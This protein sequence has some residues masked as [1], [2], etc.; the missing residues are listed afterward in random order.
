MA[1]KR[2]A[3]MRTRCGHNETV[4]EICF[5]VTAL[6]LILANNISLD[7]KGLPPIGSLLQNFFVQWTTEVIVDFAII[8]WLTVMARQPVLAVSHRL[9]RGWTLMIAV[10][11]FFGN[12]FFLCSTVVEYTYAHLAH[13]EGDATWYLLTADVEKQMLNYSTLCEMFPSPASPHC[14]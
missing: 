5:S 12:G 8:M 3:L 7:G 4:L 9:F 13:H 1:S 11:V 14:S 10:F 6:I 2:N